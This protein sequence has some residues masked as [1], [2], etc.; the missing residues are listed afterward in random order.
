LVIGCS[1]GGG[2]SIAKDLHNDYLCVSGELVKKI[3]EIPRQGTIFLDITDT[4]HTSWP[5]IGTVQ[6]QCSP[7]QII[8]A[9]AAENSNTLLIRQLPQDQN[10]IS[11]APKP[12]YILRQE[13]NSPIEFITI[14]EAD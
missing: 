6:H 3:R 11:I 1:I 12:H 10:R 8:I 7:S 14:P 2:S 4:Y 5:A 9:A 13:L